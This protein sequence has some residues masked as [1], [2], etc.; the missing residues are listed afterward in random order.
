MNRWVRDL[1]GLSR[2]E[3]NGLIVLIPLMFVMLFSAPA[4]RWYLSR[5]PE[6]FSADRARLD[7]IVAAFEVVGAPPDVVGGEKPTPFNPNTASE[8]RLQALGFSPRL[9]TRIANYRE[10]GGRF[11]VRSDLLKIYGIDSALYQRLYPFINLPERQEPLWNVREQK[12]NKERPAQ[13]D[14]QDL[15]AAD[16]TALR[17]VYGIG[18]KLSLRVV[19]FRDALGG[20]VRA[21]Q[22]YEVY[23][24]DSAVVERAL[25]T[26]YIDEKFVPRRLNINTASDSVLSAHPYL[27]RKEARAIVAYRFQH[28][29]FVGLEDLRNIHALGAETIEKIRPYLSLQE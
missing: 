26:F 23:G 12:R 2:T 13:S 28:G 27:G 5:Q 3:T 9:A 19:K 17:R 24:L 21:Q 16:T 25:R 10:K 15:N 20:F 22:L 11:R 7:S 14:R 29:E 6:D 4:W 1:F 18:H 8:E